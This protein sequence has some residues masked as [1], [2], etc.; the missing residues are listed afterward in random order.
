MFQL[1][2]TLVYLTQG[3]HLALVN[4]FILDSGATE[5]VCN[6][7]SRF[8]HFTPAG[9]DEILVASNNIVK[10]KGYSTIEITIEC[11]GT[12][13]GKRTFQLYNTVYIPSF[14]VNIV[15]YN[16]FYDKQIYW[17]S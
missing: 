12:P 7:R 15:S 2:L 8:I 3:L 11:D 9:A 14:T 10:I 1:Y 17:D 4:S 6:D 16:R 5:H 13:N